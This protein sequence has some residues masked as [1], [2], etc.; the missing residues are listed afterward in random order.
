[1]KKNIFLWVAVFAVGAM[2]SCSGICRGSNEQ[3]LGR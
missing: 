2:S 3:L 1:M